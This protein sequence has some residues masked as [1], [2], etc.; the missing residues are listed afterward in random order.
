MITSIDHIAIAVTNLD[1][2]VKTFSAVLGCAPETVQVETVPDEGVRV[3]FLPVGGTKIELLEPM[4][5]T[6]PITKFLEK[7]GD[8]MHHI[9]FA[10]DSI[11]SEQERVTRGGMRTLGEVRQG[12]GGKEILFL[13]PKDT[14]RVLLE[15]TG[16][17]PQ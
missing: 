10:T 17:K 8:G 13:H 14:N 7:N 15:L 2:A 16:K 11:K 12:A 6:S 1:E 4:N 9:A 3:A 5:D